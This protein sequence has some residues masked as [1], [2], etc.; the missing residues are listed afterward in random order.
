MASEPAG[1]PPSGQVTFLFTDIEGS[2]RLYQRLGDA[3]ERILDRHRQLCREAFAAHDGVEVA[4][5]GDGF[6]VAFPLAAGAV[7]AAVGAQRSL[8][9]ERWPEAVPLK[10]R[11]GIHTGPARLTST[12]GTYV[13]MTVHEAARVGAL[14]H[15]GQILVSGAT[16]RSLGTE[17]LP[18]RVEAVSLGAHTLRDIEGS[19]E[20]LELRGPGR[21]EE[22]T[23][24][25]QSQS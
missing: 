14:A 11:M 2:T 19:R 18:D 7:G 6:T 15:G 5:P 24:E 10:V 12:G 3:F 22:H 1:E 25:L 21:S 23:S 17:R 20:L 8:T 9:A 16:L 13:G 4:C